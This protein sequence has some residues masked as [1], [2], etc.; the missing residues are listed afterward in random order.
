[1]KILVA[2]GLLLSA[3]AA[4]WAQDWPSLDARTRSLGG[5]GVAFADGRAD[6]LYWNPATLAVGSEKVFDF[7]TGFSF[8]LNFYTDAHVVGSVATNVTHILDLYDNFDFETVQNDFNSST[9]TFTAQD[10]QNVTKIIDSISHLSDKGNGVLAEVGTGL[11]IRVGPFG[12]FVHGQANVGAIPLVDFTGV[13]F[14]SDPAAFFAQMPAP[15]ALTAAGNNLSLA[16]QGG[17]LAPADA[18]KLAFQAQQALGDAA[19][20]DPAFINA[21]TILAQGTTAGGSTLY[22]NRSGMLVRGLAQVEAGISLALPVLPTLLDVGVSFKEVISETSFTIV[23]FADKDS[24]DDLGDRVRDDLTKDN[25]KRTT[26]FN[27]DLGVRGTPFEW[28]TLGLAARNIIPMDL[29][30]AGP[31]GDLHVDPQVRFGAMVQ[32]VRF[33]KLGFDVDLMENKSPVLPGYTTRH[34]GA[35]VEFDLPV[36]KI[37][38]GYD[39]NLAFAKDHGRL[40]AGLGLD[41]FGYFILDLGVQGSLTKTEYK[42]AQVD[43][44][45]GSK[46]I[47]TDRVSVGLSLGVNLPF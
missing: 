33:I 23:T 31:G 25:R 42:A 4:G 20:S 37:R 15:G 2:A 8:S 3:G 46:T 44:S 7:S 22:D 30:F 43:G 27:M 35:G 26:K 14:S 5:A 16:M 18:D 21:M 13:G 39:D 41:F 6:S 10:V 36:L 19:I 32:P 11:N 28:L 40:T 24:E 17:G 38:V 45:E 1:M 9:P 29:A 34:L 47:P 12:L